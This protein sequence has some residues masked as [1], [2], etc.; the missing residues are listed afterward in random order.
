MLKCVLLGEVLGGKD[1]SGGIGEGG[2]A[3]RD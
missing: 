3:Y 2:R 1:K